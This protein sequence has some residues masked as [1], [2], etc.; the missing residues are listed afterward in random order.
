MCPTQT[1]SRQQMAATT[2]HNTR[3][4]VLPRGAANCK[5]STWRWHLF[6]NLPKASYELDNSHEARWSRAL[7]NGS[8]QLLWLQGQKTWR[9]SGSSRVPLQIVRIRRGDSLSFTA[10]ISWGKDTKAVRGEIS[11]NWPATFKNHLA[12]SESLQVII[13]ISQ[14]WDFENE[15]AAPQWWIKHHQKVWPCPA[16]PTLSEGNGSHSHRRKKS[17]SRHPGMYCTHNPG[18]PSNKFWLSANSAQG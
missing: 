17:Q 8:G 18:T 12:F 6:L 11:Q 5:C 7:L 10:W 3:K 13:S 1:I 14:D 16:R 4:R 9:N 2:D 15:F